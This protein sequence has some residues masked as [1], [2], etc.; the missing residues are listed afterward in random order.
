[1]RALRWILVALVLFGLGLLAGNW[2]RN[3]IAGPVA[4][5]TPAPTAPA[6]ATRTTILPVTPTATRMPAPPTQP[7]TAPLP[8]AAATP[9][10]PVE[11]PAPDPKRIIITEADVLNALASGVGAQQGLAVT[12]LAVRFADDRLRLTADSITYNGIN[13]RDLAL[14]GTLVA[15]DGRLQLRTESISPGGL[16]TALIPTLA[17]Q[18]L[19][20]YAG[21]WY[22]EAVQTLDGQLEVQI[23]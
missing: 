13:I 17:N 7:P 20:Q 4:I 12:N 14:V 19:A 9:A 22:I 16:I 21:G 23:R 2:L 8:T 10:G 3:R 5:P 15:Q 6:T 11:S 1:M 18:A